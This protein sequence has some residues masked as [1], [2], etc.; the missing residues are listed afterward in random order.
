MARRQT[1][2]RG[3]GSGD[4]AM[5]AA[6]SRLRCRRHCR[7]GL[8]SV[9]SFCLWVAVLLGLGRALAAQNRA[10]ELSD[11]ERAWIGASRGNVYVTPEGQLPPVG[12]VSDGVFEGI[13]ADYLAL[14]A[15]R[16][17]LEFRYRPDAPPAAFNRR[18]IDVIPLMVRPGSGA[19]GR[20]ISRPLLRL[21]TTLVV[22]RSERDVHGMDDL[23][24]KQVGVDNQILRWND[25]D[26]DL[27]GRQ[28]LPIQDARRGLLMLSFG[29]LDAF[30]TLLPV[31]TY[32][33]DREG[34][35]NLRSAGNLSYEVELVLAVSPGDS[36]LLGIL[37]KA[38]LG[39]TE[40][41]HARI[42]RRWVQIGGTP[43]WLWLLGIVGV[44]ATLLL[45]VTLWNRS[46]ARRVAARTEALQYELAERTRVEGALR[47]SEELHRETL[48]EI[49]DAVFLTDVEGRFRYMSPD[50]G[51]RLGV[52][53]ERYFAVRSV[54]EIVG[55]DLFDL[56]RGGGVVQDA[57]V[58]IDCGEGGQ[59]VL[60]VNAKATPAFGR[61]LLFACR[62]VTDQERAAAEIEAQRRAADEAHR[63]AALGALVSTL[64]HEVNNPNHTIMLNVPVLR[65]AWND[66][67]VVLD[68]H[69]RHHG[70]LRLANIP[71]DDMRED[72]LRLIDEI[73]RAADRIRGIVVGLRDYA[74]GHG[75][76][77][78][79]R[80]DVEAVLQ[81]AVARSR[82]GIDLAT[83]RFV[84]ALERPLPPVQASPFLLTQVFVNL[85]DKAAAELS[86]RTQAMELRARA[87]DDGVEVEVRSEGDG[88]AGDER[89]DVPRP[90]QK[91][92]GSLELAMAAW[93]VQK[94]GGSMAI[95][96]R[97]GA[98]TSVTV[99]L[100]AC[101]DGRAV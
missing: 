50:V 79:Q 63:M 70:E 86:A 68:Q 77:D 80:L 48:V 78:G 83:D 89:V 11:E 10:P 55:H 76:Q 5:A 54:A 16:T 28:V 40:S 88:V 13:A 73:H 31:A 95:R 91:A 17:G 56:A 30:I 32:V 47:E 57:R 75:N 39:L 23:R 34:I 45:G 53:A 26:R 69:Q 84:V 37:D 100:P 82:H 52:P 81:A 19:Q 87:L 24:M 59:R 74:R 71:Y 62:D 7:S 8:A 12:F 98:G 38:V 61:S 25:L 51:E 21:R 72:V 2:C 92:G 6:A 18:R 58:V 43:Y 1:R 46:L 44:L 3:R 20:V 49:S 94:C 33:M 42:Y 36:P 35:T 60:R 96:G 14:I 27:T 85:L 99:R 90:F 29:E 97:P 4:A 64:A 22:K 65:A 67:V 41:E 66:A 15:E 101:S 9:A 93:I